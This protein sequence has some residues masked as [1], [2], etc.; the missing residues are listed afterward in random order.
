MVIYYF[1]LAIRSLRRNVIVTALMIT[2]IGI[3]IG[4]SMSALT[5]LRALE[6]DPIPQKSAQLFTVQ[7]DNMGP[8]KRPPQAPQADPDEGLPRQM[9]YRDA[10][11][12]LQARR[13][14]RQIVTYIQRQNVRPAD[15]R[16]FAVKT[17]ATSADFFAMFLAPFSAGRP[18]TRADDDARA[19]VAVISANLAQRLFP[20]GDA[21][22]K[23]IRLGEFQ[24]R[25]VGVLAPWEPRPEFYDGG[26]EVFGE[27][28][29]VYIPFATIVEHQI[30]SSGGLSCEG[31]PPENGWQGM[32]DSE[33]QWIQFWVELPTATDV[34]AFREF[35]YNY[36][37]EQRQLGRF[38]WPAHVALRDVRAWLVLQHIIPDELRVSTLV[39]FSFLFVCLINATGLMLAKFSSRAT[40]YGVRRAHGASSVDIFLQCLVETT[41]VGL[42][43]GLLGLLLTALGLWGERSVL[44][45]DF[46]NMAHLDLGA[47]ALTLVAAVAA[48]VCS[49][50]FPTWRASH[51]QPAWQLKVQ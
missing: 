25:V 17:R 41:V 6:V 30:H 15:A 48:T 1:E 24:Y 47:V 38:H 32:L 18:W 37:S 16:P 23:S 40:E 29:Q 46:G 36:A 42:A 11:A 14:A 9:T 5:V 4:A 7:I 33:C 49:G 50:L 22:G 13:G 39:G 2:A 10:V 26:R 27:L 51:V 20:S 44:D 45:P 28:E 34:R 12:L 21:L 3:G 19:D 35:L 43:G 8:D 31:G